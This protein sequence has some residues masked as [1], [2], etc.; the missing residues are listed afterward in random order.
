VSSAEP[1]AT[2]CVANIGP[3]ERRKRMVLGVVGLVAGATVG[4]TLIVIGASALWRLALFVPF[5]MGASGI[6]QAKEKT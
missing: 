5:W 6:L 3:R 2:A 4:I 1:I